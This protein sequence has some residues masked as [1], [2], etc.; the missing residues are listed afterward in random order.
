M[1]GWFTLQHL[2]DFNHDGIYG[3]INLI[4][5]EAGHLVFMWSGN[6]VVTAA[7]GTLFNFVVPLA[8]AVA[9]RQRGDP[10]AA[11]VCTWW[12][13][14]VLVTAAPY[15]ADARLMALPTVSVGPGPARHD[16]NF[17]L[18]EYGLLQRDRE[19]ATRFRMSG[20]ALMLASLG[21][22]AWIST[23][24]PRGSPSPSA[25]PGDDRRGPR[26]PRTGGPG[27]PGA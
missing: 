21:W 25:P 10:F 26:P 27:A 14:S 9:F 22:G 4:L 23:G 15:V 24:H 20:L 19:V 8:A 6:D 2:R 18:G 3:G 17:L 12:A 11:S 1:L 13:A 16:W 7:G 5:H